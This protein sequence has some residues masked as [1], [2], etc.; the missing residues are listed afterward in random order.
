ML[1]C[2]SLRLVPQH[3]VLGSLASLSSRSVSWLIAFTFVSG[4]C[5]TVYA[6]DTGPCDDPDIP[7][8]V[9]P[10]ISVSTSG[11][12]GVSMLDAR[13][14]EDSVSQEED[15]SGADDDKF[16]FLFGFKTSKYEQD[17]IEEVLGYDTDMKGGFAGIDY[18]FTQNFV[19]GATVDI[20]Q[21]DTELVDGLGF[22]DTDNT[23][24]SIFAL[25][26]GPGDFYVSAFARYGDLDR[27]TEVTLIE[28]YEIFDEQEQI[29]VLDGR[30]SANQYN[31]SINAGYDFGT[32]A[33]L[34]SID[35]LL[36]YK[37][38][39]SD[40]FL[41]SGVVT[42]DFDDF[43]QDADVAVDKYNWDQ[44]TFSLGGV[45]S[46]VISTSSG[47][48]IPSISMYWMHEFM[49]DP[50][51]ITGRLYIDGEELEEDIIVATLLTP[52]DNYFGVH[53]GVSYVMPRGI[54]AYLNYETHF[55][56]DFVDFWQLTI[57]CRIEF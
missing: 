45:Y 7:C 13:V 26:Y 57:G 11:D 54:T 37:K 16:G 25:N 30:S 10:S 31:A 19:M 14:I 53:A 44:L 18:R 36:D 4:F 41:L 34:F 42:Y 20:E 2:S 9:L 48:L 56:R 49:D 28:E 8:S 6:Q 1:H 17:N 32:G 55:E 33:N 12:T 50:L 22:Q 38:I 39:K 46:R 51:P 27:E 24:I 35:T 5:S 23:G 40:N 52:D 21:N 43:S 15:D 47:V 29:A 3:A